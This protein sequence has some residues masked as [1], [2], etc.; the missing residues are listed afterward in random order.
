[1]SP[2]F[3]SIS[4]EWISGSGRMPSSVPGAARRLDAAVGAHQQRQRVAAGGDARLDTVGPRLE[5]DVEHGAEAAVRAAFAADRVVEILQHDLRAVGVQG[6]RGAHGVAGERGDGGGL[7]ALA[8]DVADHE[9]P[10]AVSGREA[11]VEVAADLVALTRGVVAR[12][13]LDA[14]DVRQR[15]RQQRALERARDL[16]PLL[17]E[18]RVVDR[19]RGAA[20]DVLEQREVVVAD[21]RVEAE[22]HHAE[23]APACGQRHEQ[24]ALGRELP[25]QLPVALVHD[26]DVDAVGMLDQA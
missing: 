13:Q 26:R 6:G 1:M 11:V 14:R 17:V 7:G 12:R 18:P 24:G 19:K 15:R 21:Q 16:R 2:G 20:R 23:R 25:D 4:V 10:G 5:R 9:R 3:R 22:R 8:A